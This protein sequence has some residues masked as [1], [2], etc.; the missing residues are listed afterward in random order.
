MQRHQRRKGCQ[1]QEHIEQE[2]HHPPYQRQIGESLVEHIGQGNEDERGTAVGRHAHREG[3]RE[4]HHA[5]KDSH[6]RVDDAYLQ[7]RL[8]QV[9]LPAE[10]R[11]IGTDTAHTDAQRVKR[12]S[13]STQEHATVELARVGLEEKLQSLAGIGQQAGRHHDD[14][15]QDKQRRHHQLGSLLYTSPHTV[16]DN[17]MTNQEDGDR[18]QHRTNGVGTKLL[19]VIGN[20]LRVAM[21]LAHYRGIDIL[22]A[23]AR[24]DGIIARDEESR[25]DLQVTYPF[26]CRAIGHLGI[27]TC[28]I[29]GTMPAYDKLGHHTGDAQYTYTQHINQDKDGTAVLSRHIG[30][31]PYVSQAHGTACRGEYQSQFTTKVCSL[32]FCH[33]LLFECKIIKYSALTHTKR[34]QNCQKNEY[35]LLFYRY[36][37]GKVSRHNLNGLASMCEL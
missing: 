35:L 27:G 11:R 6:H 1:R 4:Y 8:E 20:K 7:R 9:G 13:Q 26:P 22:Q 3:S 28:R 21:Q 37:S 16:Y 29:G 36:S 10:I 34:K 18:P 5:G 33:N 31:A 25:N 24:N 32:Q 12:L 17:K 2:G 19:E 15:K 23:P 14:K 30:E